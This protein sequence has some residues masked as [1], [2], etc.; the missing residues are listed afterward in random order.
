MTINLV[1]LR[2]ID[3]NL[4]TVFFA[5]WQ[6]RSVTRAA[7]RL[8]L[9]QA[10]VSSALNRFRK[11]TGDPLFVRAKHAMVPT[12]R[13]QTMAFSLEEQ[14]AALMACVKEGDLFDPMSSRRRFLLGASDDFEIAFGPLLIQRLSILAPHVRVVFRQTNSH[15][16][17]RML[18]DRSIEVAIVGRH[19]T[20]KWLS[21]RK[22][23]TA[24]YSCLL[25]ARSCNVSLPISLTDYLRLPH[26]LISFAGDTG[27][28]DDA[29]QAQG[30][31]RSVVA[32]LSH[33]AGAPLFLSQSPAIAT[34]PTHAAHALAC[35]FNLR[36]SRVPFDM[37]SFG[38]Y[39]VCRRDSEKDPGLCWLIDQIGLC[40]AD[41]LRPA[42]SR[43]QSPP[44]Q[45]RTPEAGAT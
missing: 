21:T 22:I 26:I 1:D 38:A 5:I 14:L 10:A 41:V 11:L 18:E 42:D 9:S 4:C 8:L 3:L 45:G 44:V 32:S 30:R 2:K 31:T 20:A 34:L 6:E 33:F 7:E 27:A 29:L 23:G 19:F 35:A 28:V 17:E 37:G 16:V 36:T 25:D 24:N 43:R 12:V 39:A 40:A 13:A 15:V